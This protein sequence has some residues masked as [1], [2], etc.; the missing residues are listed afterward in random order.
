MRIG[1]AGQNGREYVG[2]GSVMRE[3]GLIGDGPGQLVPR[4]QPAESES[5]RS[6]RRKNRK[7]AHERRIRRGRALTQHTGLPPRRKR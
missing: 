5:H 6:A 3:R 1:Y 7:E 2:V 4:D